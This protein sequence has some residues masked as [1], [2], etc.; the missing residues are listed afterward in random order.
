M[1]HNENVNFW[2]E[3][4]GE[5]EFLELLNRYKIDLS[6]DKFNFLTITLQNKNI[7]K[8]LSIKELELL[9]KNDDLNFRAP[10]Y[11]FKELVDSVINNRE[12]TDN[13]NEED[14]EL[15]EFLKNEFININ[16]K[17]DDNNNK[18]SFRMIVEIIKSIDKR[19]KNI[20]E[21]ISNNSSSNNVKNTVYNRNLKEL[22]NKYSFFILF[23]SIF[24]TFILTLL[25][26]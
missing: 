16:K 22:Y 21:I 9:L 19:L 20:E 4:F 1:A 18:D 6:N 11:L 15:I 26:K 10:Q 3:T 25:I 23:I 13:K 7:V 2:L 12:E 8:N 24:L 17:L 5:K 14:K